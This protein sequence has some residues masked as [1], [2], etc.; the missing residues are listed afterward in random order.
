M[1]AAAAAGA[2]F[3]VVSG[4]NAKS[5]AKSAA[6]DQERLARENAMNME[7]ETR[8]TERRARGQEDKVAAQ[9]RAR[10]AASGTKAGGSQQTFMD[11]EAEEFAKEMDWLRT[12]GANSAAYTIAAGKSAAD[13]TRNAGDAAMW[14]GIASGAKQAGSAYTTYDTTGSFW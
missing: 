6:R 3:S 7:S 4:M 12:S 11:S 8:E 2:I 5:D 1:A 13:A 14:S 9:R 10:A